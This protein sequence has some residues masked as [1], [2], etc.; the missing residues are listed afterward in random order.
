MASASQVSVVVPVYNCERY[1]AGAIESVLKQTVQ[2]LEIIVV[3]DGSTDKSGA[4]VKQFGSRI[5]YFRQSNLGVGPAR[6]RGVELAQGTFLAF[7][8]AD[9]LWMDY[10]LARQLSV[11]EKKP[12]HAMV[13]GHVRQF[14]SPDLETESAK[15]LKLP[16]SDEPGP[17]ASTMLIRRSAF[18]RVGLFA[19][20]WQVGEFVDWYLRAR[21]LG[22]K[23]MMIPDVVLKRRI[24]SSNVGIRLRD[25]RTDYAHILK[26][27]L[28]R[29]RRQE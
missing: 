18:D 1:L 27:S 15:R 2:A 23:S 16:K 6:N 29:R 10:K 21:E 17:L 20:K 13:F 4:V 3:D 11:L 22:L 14:L 25:K 26:A 9:D 5:Q 24:H 7:L 12:R 19:E 28:D 8:D